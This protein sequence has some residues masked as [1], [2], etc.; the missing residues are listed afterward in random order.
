VLLADTGIVKQAW[1][2]REEQRLRDNNLQR[3]RAR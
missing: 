2:V 1:E 3:E